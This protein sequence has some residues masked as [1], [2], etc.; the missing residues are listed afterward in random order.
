MLELLI[1]AAAEFIHIVVQG[2][3]TTPPFLTFELPMTHEATVG[4]VM[5]YP[6]ILQ[7]IHFTG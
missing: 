2:G 4:T 6:L 7:L 1:G 3:D 5:R